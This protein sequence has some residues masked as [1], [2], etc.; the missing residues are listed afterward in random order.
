MR[1]P[2]RNMLF[3]LS[4]VLSTVSKLHDPVIGAR[5]QT[6]LRPDLLG[7]GALVRPLLASRDKV[8]RV[9]TV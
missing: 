3:L 5:E 9:S 2:I 6:R 7:I 4:H 1:R 8:L